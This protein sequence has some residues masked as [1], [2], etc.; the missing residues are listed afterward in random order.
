M[1]GMNDIVAESVCV[2]KMP[3]NLQVALSM[4]RDGVTQSDTEAIAH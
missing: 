3:V 2:C 1:Q 4:E